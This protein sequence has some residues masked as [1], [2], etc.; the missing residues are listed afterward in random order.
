MPNTNKSYLVA[1]LFAFAAVLIGIYLG[2]GS[3][4][5]A[6]AVVGVWLFL[7]PI[8]SKLASLGVVALVPLIA[9]SVTVGRLDLAERFAE[10]LFIGL[11]V[12]ILLLVREHWANKSSDGILKEE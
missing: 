10:L 11:I 1:G 4:K 7:E 12:I 6:I 2:W 9:F 3:F 8:S 5:I